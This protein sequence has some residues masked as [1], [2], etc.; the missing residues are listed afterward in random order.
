MQIGKEAVLRALDAGLE[1]FVKALNKELEP[2]QREL[3]PD[4]DTVAGYELRELMSH[5]VAAFKERYGEKAQPDRGGKAIGALKR[6]RSHY[7]LAQ[8]KVLIS[9]YL[10]MEDEWFKKRAYDLVTLDMQVQKVILAVSTGR[11]SG[12][13]SNLE[14]AGEKIA[15]QEREVL[16]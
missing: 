9:A 10:Q 5:Y 4:K 3:L 1:A 16:T 8:V 11:Q 6:L 7:N 14:R 13:K 15:Q 12:E 2:E